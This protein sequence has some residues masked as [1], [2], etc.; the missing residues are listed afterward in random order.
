MPDTIRVSDELK[1]EL[2][3]ADTG[4]TFLHVFDRRVIEALNGALAARRPLLIRGE[5]GVGKSQI[6]FAA[7]KELGRAVVHRVVDA[8]TDARDLLWSYDAIGRLGEAQIQAAFP[9]ESADAVR[10][11]LRQQ[12]F[13]QP[14]VLWWA[15]DWESATEQAARSG[16]PLRTAPKGWTKDAGTVVL[17][18]EIDK[19]DADVP[20][21]LLEALGDRSFQVP[22]L[23][24]RVVAS[25]PA[26]LVI[27]TTNEER[28]LPDAFLR[29]CLVL[30]LKLP[31]EEGEFV[32][33]LHDRGG[34]HFP[35]MSTKVRTAA[36]QMM[37]QDRARYRQERL[38]PPGQAE[39]LDLLRAI[40][41]LDGDEAAQLDR[42][43]RLRE[44]VFHKHPTED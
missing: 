40:D 5:P 44:F 12:K 16:A 38:T 23:D 2:Q 32:E 7:A 13:V 19:A 31:K 17:L 41:A 20:N 14:G 11:A 1:T 36:A 39:Y 34:A 35:D 3:A 9:G 8:K 43:D 18:D 30:Q 26:P 24:A 6:A 15:F 37:F 33:L 28:A 42:L 4:R 10:N 27:I 21:G 29:R 25:G 22:R